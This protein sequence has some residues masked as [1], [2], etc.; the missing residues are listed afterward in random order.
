MDDH[1]VAPLIL[2]L[3]LFYFLSPPDPVIPPLSL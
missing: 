3:I 2:L 1:V